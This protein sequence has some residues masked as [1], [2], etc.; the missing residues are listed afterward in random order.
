MVYAQRKQC[1][2]A[3]HCQPN[4]D[5]LLV[6][7]VGELDPEPLSVELPELEAGLAELVVVLVDV[8]G[9]DLHK[10]V[11]GYQCLNLLMLTARL[12]NL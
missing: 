5:P 10:R 7:G 4:S 11:L 9:L 6:D 1:P 12:D 2:T 8:V 3:F